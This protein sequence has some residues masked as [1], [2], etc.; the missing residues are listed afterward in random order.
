[1]GDPPPASATINPRIMGLKFMQRRHP[2]QTP[3]PQSQAATSG[4]R[5]DEW[6]LEASG[7]TAP[8]MAG[9]VV[10]E[11]DALAATS[12]D[13]A[14]VRFRAGR[15][16]FGAFNPQLEKRLTE[17][18]DLMRKAASELDT[19]AR[20]ENKQ[21]ESRKAAWVEA[22]KAARKSVGGGMGSMLAALKTLKKDQDEAAAK[23]RTSIFSVGSNS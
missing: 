10:R 19:F 17:I 20:E 9:H 1:M 18:S 4:S 8:A 16:S 6:T 3:Q 2:K 22:K 21:I 13:G 5:P 15:R 12:D 14:L 23:Q 11:E 7:S